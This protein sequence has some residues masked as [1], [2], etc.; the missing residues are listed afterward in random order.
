MTRNAPSPS[1]LA[2]EHWLTRRWQTDTRYYVVEVTQDLF[3]Y[4]LVKRTWGGLGNHRGNS[5]TTLANDYAQA[6][7]LLE[8]VTKRR[9]QR[10]YVC[11]SHLST[12]TIEP[13]KQC[14]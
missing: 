1:P 3:G 10:G 13:E 9:R 4:W 2:V 7:K 14:R 12:P 5:V 6:L 8:E 11:T